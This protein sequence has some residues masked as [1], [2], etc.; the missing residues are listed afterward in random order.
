M[1]QA[2]LTAV[3]IWGCNDGDL[4]FKLSVFRN[5]VRGQMPWVDRE[6][7][8]FHDDDLHIVHKL[9]DNVTAYNN[10][11]FGSKRR[12]RKMKKILDTVALRAY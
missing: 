2:A 4:R 6:P 11:P 10:S 12:K 5:A 9:I 1:L 8:R 3:A 7:I